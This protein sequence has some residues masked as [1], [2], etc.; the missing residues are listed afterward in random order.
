M[1]ITNTAEWRLLQEHQARIADTHLRTIFQNDPTRHDAYQV[2]VGGICLDYSKNLIDNDVLKTLFLLCSEAR[3]P[4][5]IKALFEGNPINFTEE[6]P[7]LH[8]YL[9][10]KSF[11]N[12]NTPLLMD[13]CKNI[14]T[15]L[16]K[17]QKMSAEIR[18]KKWL[19]Y[20]GKPI[21]KIINIGIGGSHLGP[22]LVC[23]ALAQQH[24]PEIDIAFLVNADGY[25]FKQILS[26][27]HPE[28][29]LFIITSKSFSTAETL[30]NARYAKRFLHSEHAVKQQM[31]AVTANA[32]SA[33]EFGMNPDHILPIWDSIGG[34]YSVWSA[35]GL[36]IAIAFGMTEFQ[37]LLAGAEEMDSH[38][39]TA[40]IEKNMPIIMAMLSI[41]YNNF[42][43]CQS[44]AVLPYSQGLALLPQY[45]QQLVMESN[46][47]SVTMNGENT[48]CSTSP[49][50]WGGVG[51]IGQHA[52]HQLLH[53]GTRLIPADFI[54]IK[55]IEHGMQEHHQFLLA[56][57]IGQSATLAFGSTDDEIYAQLTPQ[58]YP[59]SQIE[60]LLPHYRIAGNKPS[61]LLLLEKLDAHTIGALLALYEHKTFV[62]GV[63]WGINSFDQF[64]VEITKQIARELLSPSD[65][66]KS[67]PSYLLKMTLSQYQKILS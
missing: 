65:V 42:W 37:A 55:H 39:Y 3:L 5:N 31:I 29:T 9:R 48:L 20:T 36:S 59:P 4:E 47:K 62:Q 7:A 33:I 53:Q 60:K 56:N 11:D 61:N 58:K 66:E 57:C 26:E 23:E 30:L 46:G 6:K 1:N 34:R 17:M 21:S 2:H 22:A 13:F 52:F 38:F 19:G 28:T 15:C 64:G 67:N 35:A 51:S 40:P 12:I 41:W 8:T 32:Q 45:L 44:E 43:H 10:K 54:A 16:S 49:V 24:K 63:I 27:C 50:I 25:E 18:D 14:Q